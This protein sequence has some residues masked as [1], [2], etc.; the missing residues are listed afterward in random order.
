[1]A[2]LDSIN[3]RMGKGALRLAGEGHEQRWKVRSE[4]KSPCYTTRW[5]EL[6]VAHAR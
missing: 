3:R 4:Y 2:T 5:N 6:A 1:M